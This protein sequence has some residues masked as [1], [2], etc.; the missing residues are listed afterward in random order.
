MLAIRAIYENGQMHLDYTPQLVGRRKLIVVF[1]DGED[2][3]EL[4]CDEA[5]RPVPVEHH[6]RENQD[7]TNFSLSCLEYAYSD[8]EPEYTDAMLKTVN[9]AFKP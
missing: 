4:G 1:E 3:N 6:G 8:D 7:R 9:P 5:A 2:T